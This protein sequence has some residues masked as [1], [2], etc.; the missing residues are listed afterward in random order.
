VSSEPQQ[1]RIVIA[2]HEALVRDGLRRLIEAANFKVVGEASDGR[3]VVKLALQLEPDILLLDSAMPSGL[4]VLRRL[5][6]LAPPVRGILLV[7]TA[8]SSQIAEAF[9]HGARGV[10]LKSSTLSLLT[11]IRTVMAGKA[12]LEPEIALDVAK[13]LRTQQ[14]AADKMSSSK[15]TVVQ[16]SGA[17]KYAGTAGFAVKKPG[18]EDIDAWIGTNWKDPAAA[19]PLFK[20]GLLGGSTHIALAIAVRVARDRWTDADDKRYSA[21]FKKMIFEWADEIG[22]IPKALASIKRAL[23]GRKRNG[24]KVY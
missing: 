9:R 23:S 21:A 24:K 15:P 3:E 8:E 18:S 13:Y 17:P 19:A 22:K 20:F 4:E 16:S 10:V 11:A 6:T 14:P 12:W 7:A 5:R 1:V 2:D